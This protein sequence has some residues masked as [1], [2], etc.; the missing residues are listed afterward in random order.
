MRNG[1]I[2]YALARIL[3]GSARAVV[4]PHNLVSHMEKVG[5]CVLSPGA[6]CQHSICTHRRVSFGKACCAWL[7]NR[8]AEDQ[9]QPPWR[10]SNRQAA[11]AQLP[12]RFIAFFQLLAPG[13]FQYCP[14]KRLKQRIMG[15]RLRKNAIPLSVMVFCIPYSTPIV[16]S[17]LN[18]IW[19]QSVFAVK[20]CRIKCRRNF[21]SVQ[22]WKFNNLKWFN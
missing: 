14:L 7:I 10:F 16:F 13:F 4:R 20:H 2:F 15:R 21:V 1:R 11:A 6:R 18:L 5:F 12:E 19:F 17:Y 8:P 22:K 9:R 3:T